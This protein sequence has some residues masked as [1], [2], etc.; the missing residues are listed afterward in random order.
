M[1]ISTVQMLQ[2]RYRPSHFDLQYLSL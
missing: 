1:H 2:Q